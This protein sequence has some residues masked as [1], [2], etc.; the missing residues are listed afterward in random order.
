MRL[1]S[2]Y[3]RD[4]TRSALR[5][6]TVAHCAITH[7][8]RSCMITAAAD[9]RITVAHALK[10]LQCSPSRSPDS[11]CQPPP[12]RRVSRTAPPPAVPGVSAA[13]AAVTLRKSAEPVPASFA[14]GA[15]SALASPLGLFPGQDFRLTT[16]RCS[17]CAA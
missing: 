14:S 4:V 11:P 5:Y 1:I 7:P 17:D 3:P 12:A 16:G 9:H 13:V 8:P 6:G 2:R 10:I 15:D